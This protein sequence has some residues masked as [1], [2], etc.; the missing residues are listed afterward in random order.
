MSCGVLNWFIPGVFGLVGTL[1][2][3]LLANLYHERKERRDAYTNFYKAFTE[4]IY[5]LRV[6]EKLTC[7]PKIGPGDELE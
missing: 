4:M 1:M 5:F 2:G 6:G 7:P 3:V